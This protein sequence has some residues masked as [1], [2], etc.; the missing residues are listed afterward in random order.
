MAPPGGNM[1][2]IGLY[3][4]KVKKSSCLKPQGLEPWYLVC[5]IT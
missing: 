5:S 2:Y 1:F 3:K 4:E